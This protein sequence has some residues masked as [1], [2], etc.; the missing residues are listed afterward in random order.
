MMSL[1]T[2]TSSWLPCP[3]LSS[4]RRVHWV[5]K[6]C[7]LAPSKSKQQHVLLFFSSMEWERAESVSPQQALT[8]YG[9]PSPAKRAL[10]LCRWVPPQPQPKWQKRQSISFLPAFCLPPS[11]P[12]PSHPLPL[13]LRA[14]WLGKAYY[15]MYS[16]PHTDSSP[17]STS[18]NFHSLSQIPWDSDLRN[19]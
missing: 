9:W 14:H 19:K 2:R 7:S 12:V 1:R 10:K 6:E 4:R 17:C 16:K 8:T 18:A 15:R 3:W 5:P 13:L 11:P